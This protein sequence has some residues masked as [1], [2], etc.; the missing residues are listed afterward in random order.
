MR[1]TLRR[2]LTDEWASAAT[3]YGMIAAIIALVAIFVLSQV[4]INF[5]TVFQLL[6]TISTATQG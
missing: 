1:Q 5:K 3:E 6:R 4:G 2:F